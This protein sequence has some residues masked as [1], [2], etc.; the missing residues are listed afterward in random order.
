MKKRRI[1]LN[2]IKCRLYE[3][4]NPKNPLLILLHG[5]MDTGAS[6]HFL[7][8]LLDKN[9]FCVA[10]DL[11]GFGQSDHTTNSLGYFFYEYL[12][13]LETLV[14]QLSP[15]KPVKL[16]GHSMG[17]NIAGLYAGTRPTRV[18]HLVN[19]EGFGIA[20]HKP[21]EGPR[22]MQRWLDDIKRPRHYKP[23]ETKLEV[24]KRLQQTNPRLSTEKALFLVPYFSEKTSKGYV[25]RADPK[26]KWA[27]PYLY[28]IKNIYPFWETIT[29]KVLNVVGEDTE[30]G[31]ILRKPKNPHIE[32]LKRLSHFPKGSQIKTVKNAGHMVHHEQPEEL[33]RL[34]LK[35]LS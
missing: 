7:N 29:A 6:F 17:G 15:Q 18:S 30:M 34:I 33:S 19:I 5:W 14:E 20:N 2:N 13:D 22:L 11:R 24:A 32:I 25:F 16:L 3:W 12:A 1:T 4:G 9:F 10:P 27:H 21:E 23:Y 35:F 31:H 26:H 8:E 28:Q